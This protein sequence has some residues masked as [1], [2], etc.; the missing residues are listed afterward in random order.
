MTHP[1]GSQPPHQ[2]SACRLIQRAGAKYRSPMELALPQSS[3]WRTNWC[4]GQLIFAM[5]I[6]MLIGTLGGSASGLVIAEIK[7]SKEKIARERV[8]EIAEAGA[9]YYR[10]HLA[11]VP[12]DFQDGTGVPGP[13]V[14]AFKDATG[15]TIGQYSLAITPPQNGSTIVTVESTGSLLDNPNRK[16]TVKVK[17]GIPSLSTYAVAANDV[18]R[19][20]AG[21]EVFGPIHSNDGIR[22]DGIAHNIITSSRQSYTDP[23]LPSHAADGVHTHNAN[24]NTTFLAG[25]QFPVPTI[26]FTGI[27]T[28]L[29][30]MKALSQTNGLYLSGS[31]GLGYHIRFNTNDTIDIRRVTAMSFCRYRQGS[32]RDYPDIR[33]IG[34]E[35]SFT[36]NGRSSLGYPL[37][38]NGILFA[39]DDL[40]VDGTVDGARITVVAA[41]SIIY[42]K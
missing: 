1:K 32:W 27:T 22:F 12:D 14:H 25:K 17:F 3:Q 41:R 23:D 9:E 33:S 30:N 36:L 31:G 6:I 39:E 5:I 29:T 26:D 2:Y 13:Y 15:N 8:F 42:I 24:E 18:M 37:P 7:K 16:R 28:D 11:H 21:T 19:F 10:W 35:T 40:W 20:G 38:T 4:G 34:S